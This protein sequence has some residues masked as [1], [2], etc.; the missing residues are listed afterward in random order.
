MPPLRIPDVAPV[1]T[2]RSAPPFRLVRHIL[3]RRDEDIKRRLGCQGDEELQVIEA[4]AP[5]TLRDLGIRRRAKQRALVAIMATVGLRVG[6]VARLRVS[7]YLP[8]YEFRDGSGEVGPALRIAPKKHAHHGLRRAKGLGEHEARFI[9]ALLSLNDKLYREY[10]D[11]GLPSDAFLFAGSCKRP[12]HAPANEA[13][14]RLLR[15]GGR[16]RPVLPRCAPH[17][18][19]EAQEPDRIGYSAH[20]LRHRAFQ[21]IR[22][23]AEKRLQAEGIG[24]ISPEAV[25]AA[26]LDHAIPGDALGYADMSSEQGRERWGRFGIEAASREMW[27]EAGARW[28]P[29]E[30][31]FR[32]AIRSRNALSQ[33]HFQSREAIESSHRIIRRK[34][35]GVTQADVALFLQQLDE[36]RRVVSQLR[37]VNEEVRRLRSDPSTFVVLPDSAPRDAEVVDLD[38]VE[39]EVAHGAPAPMLG[40]NPV[41]DWVTVKELAGAL[42]VEPPT[43]RRWVTGALPHKRGHPRN[44]WE[45]DAIPVDESR[46]SRR[47]RIWLGGIKPTALTN[48]QVK[49]LEG[50]CCRW[51]REQKW[52]PE[53][54]QAPLRLP[55]SVRGSDA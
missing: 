34:G 40:G 12:C 8:S 5:S 3:H 23:A 51:P 30:K 10:G 26:A 27:T 2:D 1:S 29:D 55:P 9:E 37:D 20:T 48:H 21:D 28:V 35:E 53:D 33:A 54:C 13:L 19:D 15:G 14:S 43:V 17:E 42:D 36:E 22:R 6:V 39:R 16:Q 38:A 11:G 4:L 45:R 31:R 47:R 44:P 7:D 41:R 46:G 24:G 49:D 50:I 25:V 18:V 52:S 32:R